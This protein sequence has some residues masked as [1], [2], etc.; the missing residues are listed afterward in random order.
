[1]KVILSD[2]GIRKAIEEGHIQVSDKD[3]VLNG[4]NP[5]LIQPATM[6]LEISLD[7]RDA[8]FQ[9]INS[10]KNIRQL[11]S[12]QDPKRAHPD[13]PEGSFTFWPGYDVV[14][15]LDTLVGYR[16]DILTAVTDLRSTM[17]RNGLE[18]QF[19]CLFDQ[20]NCGRVRVRNPRSYP[21]SVEGG[22]RLC[23]TIWQMEKNRS[24]N[25]HTKD[26]SER[27]YQV[28]NDDKLAQL[29]EQGDIYLGGATPIIK[30]GTILFHAGRGAT[31]NAQRHILITRDNKKI[32]LEL[33]RVE[34]DKHV[35]EPG[36]LVD[37]E[38]IERVELSPQVAV[39]VVYPGKG[40]FAAGGGWIDPG[41]K[42]NFSVQRSVRKKALE[43]R[44]GELVAAGYVWHFPEGVENAYGPRIGSQYQTSA[45]TRQLTLF[46]C[47]R[48]SDNK[49]G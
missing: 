47:L 2:A 46:G 25:G 45:T 33:N 28:T 14:C 32:G 22:T 10:L 8:E 19:S 31:R 42:G 3:R 6:D 29:L 18:T 21:I 24:V 39:H 16:E 26:Y 1:M 27:G 12:G 41:Y 11:R 44:T 7:Q 13:T 37:I 30:N 17:R 43:I 40:A 5:T 36:E 49:C 9:P 23:Q 34:E 48:D 4:K 15:K 20:G 38:T 35:I